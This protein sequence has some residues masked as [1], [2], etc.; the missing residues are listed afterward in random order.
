MVANCRDDRVAGN[1]FD[2][3]LACGINVGNIDK[4]RAFKRGSKF[5]PERSSPCV[6]MRLEHH[7]DA[8]AFQGPGGRECRLYLSR[9]VCVVVYNRVLI[10]LQLDLKPPLG[11]AKGFQRYCNLTER[12]AKFDGQRSNAQSIADIVAPGNAK[13]N[14]SKPKAIFPNLEA[15]PA[16]SLLYITIPIRRAL[17]CAIGY[18]VDAFRTKASCICIIGAVNHFTANLIK[19]SGD[20][21]FDCRQVAVEIEM[22][23]FDVQENRILRP[24]DT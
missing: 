7:Y 20:N 2:R 9:M 13:C 14:L 16:R 21:S 24:I 17:F 18:G 8:F 5:L 1:S 19:K 23:F 15:G 12:H 10:S 3:R 6:A 11:S 4:V 22:L